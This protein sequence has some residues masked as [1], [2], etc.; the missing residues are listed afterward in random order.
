M[1]G[2]GTLESCVELAKEK[3]VSQT[4]REAIHDKL[5]YTPERYDIPYHRPDYEDGYI[6]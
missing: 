1:G 5:A 4:E 6:V 2:F 3:P